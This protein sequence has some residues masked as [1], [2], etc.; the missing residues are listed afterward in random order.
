MSSSY[1]STT[2]FTLTHAKYLSSKVAT[3][4]QRLQRFYGYPSNQQIADYEAELSALLKLELVQYV[5]YGF[6]R[7]DAWTPATVRYV[8]GQG[9]VLSVDDDPGKIQAKV[10]ISG[11]TFGSYLT[12]S[13]AW[14]KLTQAERLTIKS[15][16]PFD[17]SG[18][19]EPQL[20]AGHWVSDRTYGAAGVALAR[21]SVGGV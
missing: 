1:S 9:G 6:K 5:I 7:N 19:D 20:E 2:T 10:D 21:S 14:D 3:D 17:R 12:Y 8:C 13:A 11:A 4:L 18:A 16:L 15:R